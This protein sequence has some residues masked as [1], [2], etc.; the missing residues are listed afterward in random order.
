MSQ[1]EKTIEN[2]SYV[3]GTSQYSENMTQ[4][5]FN[6]MASFV[7]SI[8]VSSMKTFRVSRVILE[9]SELMIGGSERT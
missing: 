7:S 2:G 8:A 4:S 5:T 9:C 6:T 3:K 1:S